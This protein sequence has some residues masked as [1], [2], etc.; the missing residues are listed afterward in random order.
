MDPATDH[1][2]MLPRDRLI[3]EALRAHEA[4]LRY[5]KHDADCP[6]HPDHEEFGTQCD[7]GLNAACYSPFVT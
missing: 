4:L 5:G 3:Q 7:C 1:I 6:M 2:E